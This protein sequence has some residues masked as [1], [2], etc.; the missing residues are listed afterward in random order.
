[1][2]A[3]S[4][5]ALMFMVVLFF[6]GMLAMFLFLIRAITDNAEAVRDY[7]R[8]QQEMFLDL[9]RSVREISFAMRQDRSRQANGDEILGGD[10]SSLLTHIPAEGLEKLSQAFPSPSFPASKGEDQPEQAMAKVQ[11]DAAKADPML[12]RDKRLDF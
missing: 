2:F 5:I 8:Q 12:N 1:M 6:V 10:A 9:E 7:H 4:M 11:K 3:N